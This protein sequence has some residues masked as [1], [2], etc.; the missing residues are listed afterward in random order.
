MVVSVISNLPKFTVIHV[1]CEL[2]MCYSPPHG[3]LKKVETTI[4]T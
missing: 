3:L 2:G 1:R 4:F